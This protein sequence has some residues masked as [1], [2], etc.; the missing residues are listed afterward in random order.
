M[1]GFGHSL[2]HSERRIVAWPIF[3]HSAHHQRIKSS[4]SA[5]KPNSVIRKGGCPQSQNTGSVR[6]TRVN[7]ALF[8][9]IHNPK[10]SRLL[11]DRVKP[12]KT[13]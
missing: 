9:L 7:V 2:Q 12:T 11:L 10:A 3:L 4:C 13:E 6:Y 8:R 1:F 5:V